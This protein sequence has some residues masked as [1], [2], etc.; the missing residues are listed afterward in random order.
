MNTRQLQT[1]YSSATMS[2]TDERCYASHSW[3]NIMKVKHGENVK[4]RLKRQQESTEQWESGLQA[5]ARPERTTLLARRDRA[6]LR[7]KQH[8]PKQRERELQAR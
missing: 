7:R 8:I 6:H 4:G 3:G 1:R 2:L 5:S